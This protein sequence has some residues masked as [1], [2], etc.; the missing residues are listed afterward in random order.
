MTLYFE[1]GNERNLPVSSYRLVRNRIVQYANVKLG[2]ARCKFQR[3]SRVFSA[4]WRSQPL[5]N[6]SLVRQSDTSDSR[7]VVSPATTRVKCRTINES[8]VRSGRPTRRADPLICEI[9]N[10]PLSDAAALRDMTALLTLVG[11]CREGGR[12]K[13][14]KKYKSHLLVCSSEGDRIGH[15][16][17]HVTCLVY[18]LSSS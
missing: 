9:E 4:W 13:R 12:A 1:V 2:T 5:R 15:E 3:V 7:A 6:V 14:A 17:I 11:F 16:K 18:T 8:G 10:A